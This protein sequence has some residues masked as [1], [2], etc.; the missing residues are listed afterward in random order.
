MPAVALLG[1]RQVGKT[2]LALQIAKTSR[3]PSVYLDLER[4]SDLARLSDLEAYLDTCHNKLLIIDEVQ[5]K[6]EIFRALRSTIDSRIRDGERTNQFLILGST[7]RDLLRQSSETLAGRIQ[8]LE[9]NP[10]SILEIYESNS[11]K[12]DIRKLWLRGGFPGS[13]QADNENN[14]WD[15][16]G[17][18]IASYVERDIPQMGI[19]VSSTA[20]RNFWSML[21]WENTQQIN[22]SRL[23]A[24]LGVS[25]HTIKNYIDILSSAFMVRKLSPWSGNIRKRLV[26]SPKMYLRD[27]GLA[28]RFLR[29][30]E[31]DDLLGHPMIGPSWEAFVIENILRELSD[32]WHYSYYRTKAQAEIDLILEGPRGKVLAVEVKHSTAPRISRGFHL[33]CEDIGATEKY[34]IYSGSERYPIGNNVEVIGIL[35]FLRLIRQ[36]A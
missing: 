30:S 34:V 23:G 10:F 14:S 33:A 35:D 21:A 9:L 11:D 8:F 7:S 28:H 24:S 1:A 3:K 27:S 17:A 15:W 20:M 26:K 12:F 25:Y 32:K 22:H 19:Q 36:S 29:I 6:P 18:F 16:R 31:Y 4:D 13:H 5:H 2:T